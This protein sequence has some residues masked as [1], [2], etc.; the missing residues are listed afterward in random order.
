MIVPS[1]VRSDGPVERLDNGRSRHSAPD[2]ENALALFRARQSEYEG[3][4]PR[5]EPPAARQKDTEATTR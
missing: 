2:T 3:S 1:T 5:P 4:L